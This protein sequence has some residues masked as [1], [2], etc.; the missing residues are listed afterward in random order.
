MFEDLLQVITTG[1]GPEGY[2][3]GGMV[4]F[5]VDRMT[6]ACENMTFPQ[7]HLHALIT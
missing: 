5:L 2:G 6:D 4:L 3:P 1:C 7:L